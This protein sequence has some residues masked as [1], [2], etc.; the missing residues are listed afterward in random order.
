MLMPRSFLLSCPTLDIAPDL[1]VLRK[2]A[3]EEINRIH[4]RALRRLYYDL[5]P[6]SKNWPDHVKNGSS[7]KS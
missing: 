7:T 1:D 2:T 6:V 4:K 5:T 3:N